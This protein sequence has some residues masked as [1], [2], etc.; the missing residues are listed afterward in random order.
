MHRYMIPIPLGQV[1]FN[2]AEAFKVARSFGTDFAPRRFMIKAQVKVNSRTGGYF[3]E[4]GFHGG[5]HTAN[6]IEEVRDIS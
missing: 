5:V 4:N 2:K 3:K 6:T 1:A